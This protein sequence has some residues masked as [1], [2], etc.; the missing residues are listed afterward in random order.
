MSGIDTDIGK[1]IATGLIA[2]GLLEAGINVITQKV[3]QTGCE[4]MSE[5]IQKHREMMGTGLQNVDRE[6][7][8]CSYIYSTPCSPHLAADIDNDTIDPDKIGAATRKLQAEYELVLLEGAGGLFVPLTLDY[9]LIDY[10]QD[11]GKPVILV[12]SSRLGSLNHTLAS[13]EALKTRNIELA[14]IVYNRF[15]N[16]EQHIADDS[17]KMITLYMRK[18][19]Y[20][21]PIVEMYGEEM[22]RESGS[23]LPFTVLCKNI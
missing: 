6:G 1:T 9:T 17:L 22:Y 7:L 19:G 11:I 21:S 15:G 23:C 2:R 12:T 16:S 3:V 14:G 10:F 4:G 13:L 20:D 5:D 18:Y 8:T